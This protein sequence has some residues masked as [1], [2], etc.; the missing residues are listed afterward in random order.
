MFPFK[1][2]E[3]P[4]YTWTLTTD[5]YFLL[6]IIINRFTTSKLMHACH[7]KR[8]GAF[9]SPCFLLC[10]YTPHHWAFIIPSI[11]TKIV[12]QLKGN[13]LYH[14]IWIFQTKTQDLTWNRQLH[15]TTEK[16]KLTQQHQNKKASKQTTL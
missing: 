10:F 13:T 15:H 12:S 16:I 8:T 1:C 9:R 11:Q 4:S 3:S 5:T 7:I 6:I 2:Y 14:W